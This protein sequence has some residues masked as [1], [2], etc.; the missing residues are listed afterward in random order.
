MTRIKIGDFA[1]LC[2]VSVVTLRHY[3]ELG[4]LKPLAVDRQSGYRYYGLEQLPRLNRIL[5]LK[6]LGCSL[7]QI[8]QVLS[9]GLTHEQLSGMLRLKQAE[10]AQRLQ[11]DQARLTRIAARIRQIE[12]EDTMP[13]Y[14]VVLKTVPPLLVAA[15]QLRIPTNDQVPAYLGAAYEEIFQHMSRHGV[16][17]SG[18]CQ[19]LWH[20]SADTYADELAEALVPIAQ[21]LPSTERVQRYE[22]PARQV[23]AAVHHGEFESFTQLHGALLSW[24]EANGYRIAGPF[25]EIY[26]AHD[27]GDKAG[28]ATEIQYPVE[29]A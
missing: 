2:Q 11:E 23:A 22:L 13:Q 7:E 20:T 18:P 4:L 8:G 6:D 17:A 16:E 24:I 14:E 5:A 9:E 15:R 19:A 29:R 25:C 28:S 21:P 26:I 10:L 27:Q 3:D 12:Q 1:R